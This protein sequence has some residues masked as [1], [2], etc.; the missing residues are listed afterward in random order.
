MNEL[1]CV[2]F[3]SEESDA[4]SRTK[5][6][7]RPVCFTLKVLVKFPDLKVVDIGIEI[8]LSANKLLA[9]IVTLNFPV[10]NPTSPGSPG[11][12]IPVATG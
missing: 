12:T 3:A 9:G 2:V 8:I 4:G 6:A 1:V 7:G 11:N 5:Y 10:T